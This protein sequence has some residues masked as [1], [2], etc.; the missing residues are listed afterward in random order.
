MRHWLGA[1]ALLAAVAVAGCGDGG[2]KRH[3]VSGTVKYDG[4]PIPFGEVLFTP[5]GA[6]KNS[7]PQGFA[8][9][10]DGKYDTALEGGKGIGGGPMI[11]RVT[12]FDGPGG[13]LLCE[14]EQPAD[15]PASDTTHNIDVPKK[16][17]A[18]QQPAGKRPEI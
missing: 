10:R 1:A 17:A 7:G 4:Q 6:K 2:P 15:L 3:R 12:G 18:P 14:V 11:V 8:N 13:K 16:E 5:D 9:I